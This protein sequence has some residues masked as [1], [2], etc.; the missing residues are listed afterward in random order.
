M[1]SIEKLIYLFVILSRLN[2]NWRI[3]LKRKLFLII[4]FFVLSCGKNSEQPSEGLEDAFA[5]RKASP[6]ASPVAEESMSSVSGESSPMPIEQRQENQLGK[7]FSPV[8]NNKERLLEYNI[9]LAYHCNDLIK[10]R[11][12]LL[13]FI[14][15]YGY[16]ESSSAVNSSSPYMTAKMHISSN[17]LYDALQELDKLGLLLS[18]DITTTDHTEEM[19]WQKRKANRE[20]LRQ[21]RRYV[22]SSQ[23]TAGAKNWQQVEDSVSNSEDQLDLAEHESWKITDRVKWATIVVSFST[24]VPADA[25]EIPMY[26]NAFIGLLNLF[27]E[28]SYYFIW[29]FP[30]ALAIGFTIFYLRK[31]IL[32]YKKV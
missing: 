16:L 9:Q 31:L 14:S 3:L 20:T 32:R 24:P 12:E 15:K 30:F 27:L 25:I 10:T 17:S 19:A 7:I 5:S 6:S 1:R 21:R 23:I 22:A 11:K 29:I 26:K 2:C 28:L 8:S 18:E 13:N 4:L